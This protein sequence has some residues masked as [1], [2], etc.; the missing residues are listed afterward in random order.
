LRTYFLLLILF[1]TSLIHASSLNPETNDTT[2]ISRDINFVKKNLEFIRSGLSPEND[3]LLGLIKQTL[4]QSEQLKFNEGIYLSYYYLGQYYKVRNLNDSAIYN[5]K[6]GLELKI[7]NAEHLERFYMHLSEVLRITGNYS[8]ALENAL[9][10]KDL[11]ENQEKALYSYQVYNLLALSYQTLL[12]YDL[13]KEN[14]EKSAELAL[15]HDNEAYAGIVYSNIGKLLFDQNKPDESLIYFEKGT[16]LEEKYNLYGSLGNSYTIIARIFMRKEMLDSAR[17]Y[18]FKATDLNKKA[19]NRIGI[20]YTLM[21]VSEYY[22][23]SNDYEN[24]LAHLDLTLKYAKSINLKG[25]LSEAYQLK[26]KIYANQNKY[27]EAYENFDLFFSI[28]SK[29]F[30]FKEIN[31]VK[32]L[33]QKLKKQQQENEL[34]EVKLAKQ[35]TINSLLILIGSLTFFVGLFIII[36]L[37][38]V[39]KLN[40]ELLNSK[41]KAEESDKLKSKFLQTI[42]HEIRTPLNG[43]V[44]FSEMIKSKSLS[45]SELDQINTMI[46]K[47]TDDLISTIENLVDIA[48]LS[49]NQYNVR[50]TNFKILPV[51]ENIID[52]AKS[53]PVYKTKKDL[54]IIFEKNGEVELHTDKSII[55]KI[56]PHLLKNAILYTE[57]GSITLGYKIEK[58]NLIIYVRDTGIGIPQEKIDA[59]FFPFTQGDENMSIKVGGTG[60]GLTIVNA[61]IQIL[62]GKIWVGSEL[63]KGS[64]FYISLP[65]S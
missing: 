44:G 30:D 1:I 39:K 60:L 64:T 45:D 32:S 51:L 52:K 36:Y 37:F 9:K 24:A 34:Y 35:K 3:S 49:T 57:K 55:S 22:F 41:N 29:L 42:S 15:A 33:E 26:A 8:T 17:S 28:Y 11:V 25:V 23:L 27:R 40:K 4:H 13:A 61:L 6:K 58:S 54:E 31:N 47:N 16:K 46:N 38:K 62:G 53:S 21:S 19:N 65:I 48:H 59:I 63:K 56:I 7:E 18:L 20:T 14:F 50:K 5:Y 2:I 12:E 10:L 43:I